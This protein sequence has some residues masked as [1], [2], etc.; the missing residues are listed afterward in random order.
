MAAQMTEDL[1]NSSRMSTPF[2]LRIAANRTP[3]NQRAISE[4][5]LPETKIILG[6]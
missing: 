6:K 2:L 1:T 3:H 4:E 5:A